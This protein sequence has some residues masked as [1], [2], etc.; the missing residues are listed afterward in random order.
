MTEYNKDLMQYF[1][2][3]NPFF[4]ATIYPKSY[5]F[6]LRIPQVRASISLGSSS[7]L[8]HYNNTIGFGSTHKIPGLDNL[9]LEVIQ[10]ISS[11]DKYSDPNTYTTDIIFEFNT[12]AGNYF[13]D[14]K[15]TRNKIPENYDR[16]S[17]KGMNYT[18]VPYDNSTV[19]VP[20]NAINL[21]EP[22]VHEWIEINQTN[23]LYLVKIPSSGEGGISITVGFDESDP[24][25]NLS[26]LRSI[27][28]ED[29]DSRKSIF[30]FAIKGY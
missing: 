25:I 12:P 17:V 7:E 3:E 24:L 16:I 18:K 21:S 28:D 27:Y 15:A 6:G 13:F 14:V 2:G 9:N 30:P 29:P 23:D 10:R 19:F 8:F 1:S 20:N 5:L 11:S 22:G 4:N 26:K